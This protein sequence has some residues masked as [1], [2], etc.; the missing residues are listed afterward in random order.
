MVFMTLC[1]IPNLCSQI[2][3]PT[4]YLMAF[5]EGA[6]YSSHWSPMVMALRSVPKRVYTLDSATHGASAYRICRTIP[7]RASNP[8]PSILLSSATLP[9]TRHP[10]LQS[11]LSEHNRTSRYTPTCRSFSYSSVVFFSPLLSPFFFLLTSRAPLSC[12][13]LASV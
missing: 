1:D 12:A 3:K 13:S 5:K 9:T 7:L 11:V 8:G 4:L 2:T 10:L 6:V